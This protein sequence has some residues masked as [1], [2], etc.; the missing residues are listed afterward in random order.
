[1]NN[2][3]DREWILTQTRHLGIS[4]Q[5]LSSALWKNHKTCQQETEQWV[6]IWFDM[7]IKFF[8]NVLTLFTAVGLIYNAGLMLSM[9]LLRCLLTT[10][11]EKKRCLLLVSFPLCHHLPELKC[12]HCISWCCFC[13]L[14]FGKAVELFQSN[15]WGLYS[16]WAKEATWR[17]E[18][19]LIT[20]DYPTT[21]REREL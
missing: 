18:L 20:L 13:S 8:R 15:L 9:Q 16:L 19:V 12:A 5:W 2:L 1:M 4:Q 3:N 10:W 14:V 11:E 7:L 21:E 6:C 17:A